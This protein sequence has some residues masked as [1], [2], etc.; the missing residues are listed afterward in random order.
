MKWFLFGLVTIC[1]F[2]LASLS[3]SPKNKLDNAL[4]HYEEILDADI[5]VYYESDTHNY[6]YNAKKRF[7]FCSSFKFLVSAATLKYE[8]E[9][10]LN[11]LIRYS[12]KDLAGY[13]PYTKNRVNSGMKVIE[14]VKAVHFSDN[15]ATN[16]LLERLGGLDQ[17][18]RFA[19]SV[20]D[21]KFK[22]DNYEPELN[23]TQRGKTDNT[24]TPKTISLALKN[25][26]NKK[27]L[28]QKK[29]DFQRLYGC[30]Q[31]RSI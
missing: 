2:S 24:T 25:I 9:T 27:I 5:G 12:E 31:Y 20:G 13:S 26:L 11:Q 19:I 15:T 14:L 28:V 10:S 7:P 6:S 3:H 23:K 18:N 22:L 30:K 29:N 8:T 16:I 17:M 21:Y 1:S 4:K